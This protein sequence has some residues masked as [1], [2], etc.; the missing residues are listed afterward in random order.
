MKKKLLG[1]LSFI[2]L[3][4]CANAVYAKAVTDPELAAAIKLYKAQDYAS[5]YTKLQSVIEKDSPSALAYYY[6]AIAATQLGRKAEAIENYEKAIS[7]SPENNNISRFSQKGKR[8]LEEPDKCEEPIFSNLDDEFIL[9][10][11]HLKSSDAV[12]M[13]FERLKLENIRREINRNDNIDPQRFKEYR[14][15]SSMNIDGTPSNDEVVAALR[16]LQ[17]AGLTN[18]IGLNN[19]SDVSMLSGANAQN[20][21]YGMLGNGSLN[22]QIIQAMMSTNMMQGF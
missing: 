5:C 21:L 13:D 18:V 20:S 2:I 7:L 9:N 4:S 19:Y 12:K 16:V 22:P 8:C 14:D 6:M 3:I 15:F 17:Q 1:L 11:K 10:Q